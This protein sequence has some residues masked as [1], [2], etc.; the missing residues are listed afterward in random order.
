MDVSYILYFFLFSFP[1]IYCL[2]NSFGGIFATRS[3]ISKKKK[4]ENERNL[5]GHNEINKKANRFE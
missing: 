2:D 4:E 3:H 5:P 1:E